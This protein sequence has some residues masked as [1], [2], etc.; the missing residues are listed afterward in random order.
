MGAR[1]SG[2]G[3][4]SSCLSDEWS[5]FNNIGALATLKD[6]KVGFTYDAHPSF[7]PF[8]KAAMV[9][10]IPLEVGVAGLGV[11]RT[12]DNLYNEQILT[13]GFSSK[14]GLASLGIK[15]NYIQYNVD[16]F[17]R[18]GVFSLSFGGVAELTPRLSVGAYIVNLNQPKLSIIDDN[19]LPTQLIAGISFKASGKVIIAT[20]LE[21]DLDYPLM[22]KSGME[23][24]IHKKFTV[25]T[26]FNVSPT[27]GFMGFGF[28]PRKFTLDYACQYRFNLGMR[29]QATV[30]Y[31]F[32]AKEK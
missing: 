20:E 2:L 25:R 27:G 7:K 16:G 28:N 18:K 17:G 30:G 15:L 10:V 8:N 9:F 26:G 6:V 14:F 3:Y 5:I 24:Q 4:A 19:R 13:A 22:W 31:K 1:A 29:H 32:K 12:G 11:Y 21:K 23:C